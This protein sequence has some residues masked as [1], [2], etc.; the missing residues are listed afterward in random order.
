[1]T[2]TPLFFQRASF[3]AVRYSQLTSQVARENIVQCKSDVSANT[4]Y[5]Q[6]AGQ[7]A[8]RSLMDWLFQAGIALKQVRFGKIDDANGFRTGSIV[9]ADLRDFDA[10]M[11]GQLAAGPAESAPRFSALQ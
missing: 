1:M 2:N 8:H 9:E 6:L 7:N 5:V 10:Y 4:L 11:R 3:D